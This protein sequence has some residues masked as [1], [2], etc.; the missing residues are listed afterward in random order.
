MP[1]ENPKKPKF[2]KGKFTLG[3]IYK[4]TFGTFPEKG[5]NAESDV[6]ALLKC[7][8]ACK[9]DFVKVTQET[10]ISFKNIKKF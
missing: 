9:K 1:S 7:A 6:I 10:S 8:V 5:H 3:G 2:I 4:R